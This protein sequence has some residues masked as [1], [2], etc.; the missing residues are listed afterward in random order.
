MGHSARL[1]EE[2]YQEIQAR[3]RGGVGGGPIKGDSPRRLNPTRG[4]ARVRMSLDDVTGPARSAHTADAA[5]SFPVQDRISSRNSRK[6]V[7]NPAPAPYKSKLE[8]RFAGY[9]EI[10]RRLVELKQYWY[11]PC[12]FRLPGGVR[13]TPDYLLWR[14]ELNRP[15]GA[16]IMEFHEVKGH[17]KNKRDSL[18]RLKIAA[19][20]HPWARWCLDEWQDGRWK[21][22]WL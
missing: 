6:R 9:L 4:R 3:V 15:S 16:M 21:E 1:T 7:A 2:E 11:E 5:S 14:G 22:T 8:A 17:H 12:T 10:Q 20:L 18:T 13:Y 19:A